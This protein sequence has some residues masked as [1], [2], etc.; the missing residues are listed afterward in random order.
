MTNSRCV[1]FDAL[2]RMNK[3]ELREIFTR[4]DLV[5]IY[6]NQIDARG[7]AAKTE[8]EVFNACEE[9]VTEIAA[10]IRRLTTNAN[11]SHFFVTADHGFIYKRQKLAESDKITSGAK[12]AEVSHRYCISNAPVLADGVGSVSL[13]IGLGTQDSRYVSYPIGSDIFKSPGGM[14]YCHGGSSPQEMIVPVLEVRT[15]RAH[16]DVSNARIAL[17][18]LCTKVTRLI[19]PLDFVQSEPV[20]DTVKET[21][22]RLYFIDEAGNKISSEQKLAADSKEKDTAKRMTKLRFNFKNQKYS[23][24]GKYYLVAIDEQT[25]VEL[26]R[27]EVVMDV[28]FAGNFGFGH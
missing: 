2:T 11:R 20:G 24:A 22:Y 12:N 19:L 5:Y 10:M 6:H 17:V 16:R 9:A 3:D 13:G 18:S 7:D 26:F 25:D 8:N 27:H 21:T 1:Q 15:E 14:N 4:Q 28:A 23:I